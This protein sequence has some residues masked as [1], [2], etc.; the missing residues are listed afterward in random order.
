[1]V[2]ASRDLKDVRRATH[3]PLHIS[4]QTHFCT[5]VG[6]ARG[7][8]LAQFRKE[9]SRCGPKSLA[10]TTTEV[11]TVFGTSTPGKAVEAVA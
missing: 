9:Q 3:N 1:M 2:S 6:P 11:G 5:F 4:T 8:Q 10:S 7:W